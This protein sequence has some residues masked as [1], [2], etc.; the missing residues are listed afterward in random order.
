MCV[1][2]CVCMSTYVCTQENHLRYHPLEYY[3]PPLRQAISS[4]CRRPVRLDLSVIKSYGSSYL[5]PPGAAITNLYHHSHDFYVG[6]REYTLVLMF[7]RQVV[8]YWV[9]FPGSR[10][11]I[12]KK[13]SVGLASGAKVWVRSP[14]P[15]HK[16][17]QRWQEIWVLSCSAPKP[18]DWNRTR[19]PQERFG[20]N[21]WT[22][23]ARLID[24]QEIKLL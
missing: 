1:Y 23:E 13:W 16:Y 4:A 9:M 24:L 6:S 14:A 21:Q 12:K 8:I 5:C 11:E 10:E 17:Q 7:T 2:V 18:K 22:R 3:P 20:S 15:E 19:K